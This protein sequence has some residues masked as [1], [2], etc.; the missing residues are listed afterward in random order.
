MAERRMFAKAVI[1]SDTFLD[2]PV[3]ARLLYFDLG[4]R[5]DDDGFV[6]SPK[7]IMRLTGASEDDLKLLVVKQFLIPFDSGVVVVR[8]WKIHNYVRPDRYKPTQYHDEKSLVTVGEAGVYELWLPSGIPNSNQVSTTCLPAG[9]ITEQ[10]RTEDNRKEELT[11]DF[12]A[13]ALASTESTL[14]EFFEAIWELYPTKRGKGQVSKSKKQILLRIGIA[15]LTRCINRYKASKPEWQQFQ[16]GSTFFNS[17][18][19]DYLDANY[20]AA[21]PQHDADG[22]AH[23]DGGIWMN[24]RQVLGVSPK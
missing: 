16:N 11:V 12:G 8:H 2:M 9:Y 21:I 7:R 22:T 14:D 20:T 5:G 1:E 3:S 15:E 19:V 4:M 13:D 18:Y 10:N 23:P 6:D 17:G 24:G